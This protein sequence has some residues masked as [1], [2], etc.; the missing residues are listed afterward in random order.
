MEALFAEAGVAGVRDG[1]VQ[2][3]P[4]VVHGDPRRF[5]DWLRP[6]RLTMDALRVAYRGRILHG[7]RA[8]GPRSA[9]LASGSVA[10][11]LDAGE[12]LYLPD[13]DGAVP[14]CEPWLR[15]F[16]RALDIPPGSA[17]ATAWLAPAGEGTAMHFDAEDVVS[18]Q[19]EGTKLYEVDESAALVRPVGFQYGP[20]IPAAA[21]LYPQAADGFPDDTVARLTAVTLVP[22]SVLV[23]PR[24]HWHRTRCDTPSLAVSVILNPPTRLDWLLG[25][26]RHRAL[27]HPEWRQPLYGTP[28]VAAAARAASDLAALLSDGDG[29]AESITLQ[30]I[31]T[32]DLEVGPPAVRVDR[33]DGTRRPV[34]APP[35]ALVLW[36]ALGGS[37]AAF[38]LGEA[39]RRHGEDADAAV[40]WLVAEGFLYRWPVPRGMPRRT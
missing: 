3:E 18:I 2:G 21:D 35:S 13:L 22:G 31:P 25:M 14:D 38:R 26:L 27:E 24:G 15:A 11:L 8:Q 12:A 17:R 1:F 34:D 37:T 23:Q 36:R 5:P 16:E 33:Y 4:F 19:V 20:G 6:P 40:A 10:A 9:C 29:A 39:R 28:A 32:V 7:R 30:R